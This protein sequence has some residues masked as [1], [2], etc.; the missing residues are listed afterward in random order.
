MIIYRNSRG[1]TKTCQKRGVAISNIIDDRTK[2]LGEIIRIDSH[3]TQGIP[4]KF[5]ATAMSAHVL[6]KFLEDGDDGGRQKL[7]SE[8]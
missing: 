4:K 5:E 7:A 3:I 1:R 6:D 2:D 8:P